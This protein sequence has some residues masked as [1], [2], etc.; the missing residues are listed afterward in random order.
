MKNY[1]IFLLVA[2]SVLQ[3][4][5]CP[6]PVDSGHRAD[7][8]FGE[9]SIVKK[10][11]L[12]TSIGANKVFETNIYGNTAAGSSYWSLVSPEGGAFTPLNTKVKKISGHRL[13][14]FGLVFGLRDSSSSSFSCLVVFIN[15][16]SEYCVGL[17]SDGDFTYI[18]QWTPDNKIQSGYGVENKIEVKHIGAGTFILYI[19][20]SELCRFEDK[21]SAPHT[22]GGFGYITVVTPQEDFPGVP[23]LV[24]FCPGD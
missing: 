10:E 6:T 4:S 24:E 7:P 3:L 16:Q 11:S 14:A 2:F 20:S 8:S 21:S 12:F 22:G 5:S 19:N 13:G 17:I 1:C 23:V 15:T 18:E 9:T